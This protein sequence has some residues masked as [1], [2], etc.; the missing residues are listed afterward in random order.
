MEVTP[1][2]ASLKTSGTIVG[3]AMDGPT[4]TVP[5]HRIQVVA[6]PWLSRLLIGAPIGVGLVLAVSGFYVDDPM[7][8]TGLVAV[9]AV[10]AV[11]QVF[12]RWLPEAFERL[13]LRQIVGPGE[14]ARYTFFESGTERMMNSRIGLVPAAVFVVFALARYPVVAGGLEAFVFGTGPRSLGRAGPLMLVDMLGE[15]LLGLALGLVLWRMI[16][17]ALKVRELGRRFDLHL[18]LDHPDRCGGF[19]PI[20]DLCLWNAFL[21][22]VP[23]VYLAAWVLL[24]PR[25]PMYGTTYVGLH[26]A[27]LGVLAVLAPVT[28]VAPLWT[29]HRAMVREATRLRVEVEQLGQQIDRLSRDLLERSNELKPDEVAALARDIDVRQQS[30]KRSE[31]IP[32]WPIDIS[33]AFR[34]GTSQAI[35]LLS[36]TGL[37]KPVIDAIDRLA[38]FAA[39]GG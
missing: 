7:F 3:A 39:P 29:I 8:G 13:R 18:Q 12:A 34:F 24:A 22:T 1:A 6:N 36:L 25:I 9:I 16:V 19:R 5:G 26:T 35:P 27:F 23:A 2:A 14:L 10:F 30:Y 28:F 31:Q 38:K 33:L 37:G 32:T 17:A 21:V 4:V 15:A 11:F 20:G